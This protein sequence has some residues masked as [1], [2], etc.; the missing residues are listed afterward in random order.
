[1]GVGVES[2]AIG[3]GI[4]PMYAIKEEEGEEGTAIRREGE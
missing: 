1:M 4:R 2:P 3:Q